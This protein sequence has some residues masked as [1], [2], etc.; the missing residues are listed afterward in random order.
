MALYQLALQ[1]YIKLLTEHH[2]E[3]ADEFA[4]IHKHNNKSTETLFLDYLRK[5]PTI[6]K[7]ATTKTISLLYNSIFDRP[8]CIE[9]ILLLKEYN[10]VNDIN[11]FKFNI[12][13]INK[14]MVYVIKIINNY[15]DTISDWKTEQNIHEKC[16]YFDFGFALW[17]Y[18]NKNYE[19]LQNTRFKNNSNTP[20]LSFYNKNTIGQEEYDN[21]LHEISDEITIN[22]LKKA[23]ICNNIYIIEY[24]FNT[25][26]IN[27]SDINF[28]CLHMCFC[29]KDSY[30]DFDTCID[31]L[32]IFVNYGY[33]IN[34]DDVL[35]SYIYDFTIKK[36]YMKYFNPSPNFFA[37]LKKCTQPEKKKYL[38]PYNAKIVN[39]IDYI[40]HLFSIF[41]FDD[42]R[43]KLI[44]DIMKKN[45]K[46]LNIDHVSLLPY[47][48]KLYIK[49][50]NQITNTNN[51]IKLNVLYKKYVTK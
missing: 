12:K 15:N 16:I 45:I 20:I 18:K 17:L 26:M 43:V 25:N 28:S 10:N 27:I 44:T 1:R 38:F 33:I 48:K 40:I 6:L 9:I 39:T 8:T 34:D 19:I 2:F 41:N 22:Y 50:F 37:K 3:F 14:N 4:E 36:S 31:I 47:G 5:N 46:K 32:S 21:F 35:T 13:Y 7:K 42:E 29:C 49:L 23:C 30:H 24:I 11:L 51:N